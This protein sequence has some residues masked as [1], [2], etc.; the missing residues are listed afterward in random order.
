VD[1]CLIEG[2]YK[3]STQ[4][5]LFLVCTIFSK[6]LSKKLSIEGEV[7]MEHLLLWKEVAIKK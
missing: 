6:I 5:I 2:T 7:M 3:I 4:T 1:I